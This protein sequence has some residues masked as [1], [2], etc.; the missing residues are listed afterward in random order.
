MVLLVRRAVL[1]MTMTRRCRAYSVRVQLQA[2]PARRRIRKYTRPDPQS[3]RNPCRPA[4]F[5]VEITCIGCV[6]STPAPRQ[7]KIACCSPVA[8]LSASKKDTV[9]TIAPLSTPGHVK[10]A[11]HD[12]LDIII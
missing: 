2:Y 4:P 10:I 9:V 7:G 8:V 3:T 12:H 1:A 11:N 5:V 6:R